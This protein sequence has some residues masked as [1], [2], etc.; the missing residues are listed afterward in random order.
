MA[1]ESQRLYQSRHEDADIGA[2]A[3]VRQWRAFRRFLA[4]YDGDHGPS[5]ID[6]GRWMPGSEASRSTANFGAPTRAQPARAKKMSSGV[7]MNAS[8]V[9]GIPAPRNVRGPMMKSRS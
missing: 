3:R 1:P 7:A 2:K 6:I 9:G 5:A 8:D 4:E